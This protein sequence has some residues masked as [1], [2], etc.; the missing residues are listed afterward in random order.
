MSLFNKTK[1]KNKIREGTAIGNFILYAVLVFLTFVTLYPVYYVLILSI[2]DPMSAAA[3]KVYLWPDGFYL[4]TYKLIFENAKM[5]RA[6]ANT[7]LY[8]S[9]NTILILITCCLG[10]YPLTYKGLVGRKWVNI[11]LIIP[12]YFGGGLIPTFLLITRLGMYNSPLALIIP[13]CVSIWYIIL[14]KS[15]FSSLPHSLREAAK[16]DGANNYQILLQIFL[17]MSKPIMAVIAVYT[18]VGVW[19]A[20]FSASVYLPTMDWQPLQLYLRRVLVNL[21]NELVQDLGKENAEMIA[22][23]K[24]SSIQMRYA[25]IIFSTLPIMCVYPFFQKHF[26]KG[27]MLGSLKE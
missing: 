6:Y 11:F 10:A 16:I 7:I 18:I 14:T 2:S 20:W 1:N 12:M 23:Q 22:R 8:A 26:V 3:M 27:V 17:P 15:Y 13:S 25:L 21:S 9:V 4:D 5:W 19:N 24:L